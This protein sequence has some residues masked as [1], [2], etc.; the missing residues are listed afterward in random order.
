MS[1]LQVGLAIAGGLGLAALVAHGTWQA[2]RHQ[3]RR[4]A[5]DESTPSAEGSEARFEPIGK[6]V[7]PL[8]TPAASVPGLLDKR[9]QL[10]P[11]IDAMVPIGL[12]HV[13]SGDAVLAA[14]P[15]TRRAGSKPFGIEGREETSGQWEVP[16]AGRRYDALQAGVQLASRKGALNEIEYSEFVVKLQQFADAVGG[17]PEF[18]DM[19]EEV[20]RGRELDQFASEHDAQLTV[21]LRARAAAWSPGYVLQQAARQGFVPSVLPGR[22]VLPGAGNSEPVL[23]L[24]F[25]TQAAL[26]EDPNDAAIYEL[27]LSLD[28]PH[29]AR[30]EDPFE[31]M[32][33]AALSLGEAMDGAVTDD[34]GQRLTAE[35]IASINTDL[36]Q[37][38]DALQA[39]E[40]PA[41]SPSARRLFS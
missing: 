28:V 1:S 35:A 9:L 22:L 33:Q 13:V 25:D 23:S 27:S 37:L 32:G 40:L 21:C 17:S 6:P 4:A 2:R 12:D 36:Q 30:E 38:Y 11:L 10:D 16:Q 29:V 41:G 7:S 15:H 34:R 3:P 26:A 39:H 24:S 5:P 19:L 31:R 20:A 18:P 14:L 8:G